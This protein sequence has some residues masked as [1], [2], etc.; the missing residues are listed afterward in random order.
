MADA[1]EREPTGGM[2]RWVKVSLVIVAA[3][4]VLFV[5]VMVV[6][7]GGGH[8]PGNG[9]NDHMMGDTT[10]EGLAAVPGGGRS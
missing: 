3:L 2:P 1:T 4:A 8:G 6:G 7:D 10:S 9:P 5:V